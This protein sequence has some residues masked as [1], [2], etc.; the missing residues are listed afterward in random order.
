[1]LNI[2]KSW[3]NFTWKIKFLNTLE[4]SH[5][6]TS[7]SGNWEANVLTSHGTSEESGLI[8]FITFISLNQDWVFPLDC[9]NQP[10]TFL[11]IGQINVLTSKWER[12]K[13]TSLKNSAPDILV[14]Q[15][16]NLTNAML[17]ELC[18][19]HSNMSSIS[20][21]S[22]NCWTQILQHTDPKF[23]HCLSKH[24]LAGIHWIY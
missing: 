20:P 1:M 14:I 18:C 23:R 19:N 8:T 6:M 11:T 13:L 12:L 22:F 2:Q 16:H 9:R 15:E 10:R 3:I 7:K 24:W 17:S 21:K 4:Y 5:G